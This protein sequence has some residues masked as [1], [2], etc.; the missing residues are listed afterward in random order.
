MKEMGVRNECLRKNKR[1][2]KFLE[3]LDK[4]Y[5][6]KQASLK[7]HKDV[8]LVYDDERVILEPKTKP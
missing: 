6:D 4:P 8:R 2:W 3:E 1:A 5:I 7:W